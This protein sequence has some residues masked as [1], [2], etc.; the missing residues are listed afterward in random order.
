MELYYFLAVIFC[1]VSGATHFKITKLNPHTR[2]QSSAANFLYLV[3]S[4]FSNIGIFVLFG[5]GLYAFP[6]PLSFVC[7][8]SSLFLVGFVYSFIY[9]RPAYVLISFPLSVIF[10]IMAI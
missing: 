6:W 1:V 2:L 3:F 10:T 7:L 4:A 8:F 5:I 9:P